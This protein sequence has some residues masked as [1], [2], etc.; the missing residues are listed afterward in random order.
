MDAKTTDARWYEGI[1]RLS[2]CKPYMLP[3]FFLLFRGGEQRISVIPDNLI[4]RHPPIILT[5][6]FIL[7]SIID[8]LSEMKLIPPRID[9]LPNHPPKKRC[10]KKCQVLFSRLVFLRM[11]SPLGIML[12]L[13]SAIARAAVVAAVA[14]V[15]VP[16]DAL[17][18]RDRVA[19]RVTW[20]LGEFHGCIMVYLCING[21][22]WIQVATELSVI[23]RLSYDV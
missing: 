15:V 7:Y 5:S 1:W 20:T 16:H 10:Q 21:G 8:F 22:H 19:M 2:R 12:G 11:S 17:E 14:A 4:Q 23:F 3:Y 13:T 9:F 18:R 6:Y